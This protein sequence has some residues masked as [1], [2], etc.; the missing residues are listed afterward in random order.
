MVWLKRPDCLLQADKGFKFFN[1]PFNLLLIFKIIMQFA[2]LVFEFHLSL[3]K[4]RAGLSQL[5]LVPLAELFSGFSMPFFLLVGA[6]P[7]I[8]SHFTSQMK[9]KNYMS[10][11]LKNFIN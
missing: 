3:Q 6:F 2:H 11:L 8:L 4:M 5:Q 9:F 1:C 7:C 10:E